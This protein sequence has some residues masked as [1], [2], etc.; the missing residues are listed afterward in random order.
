[1]SATNRRVDLRGL[2]KAL[3]GDLDWITMKAL[4]KDRVRRY[5][6]A[7]ALALDL[8]RHLTTSRCW[9]VRQAGSIA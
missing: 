7:H 8:Q 1:V 2:A 3:E 4:E 9:R 6:T 5:E